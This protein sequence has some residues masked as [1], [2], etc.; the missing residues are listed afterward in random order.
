M[1]PGQPQSVGAL[2]EQ[3]DAKVII[4]IINLINSN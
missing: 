1:V 3:L 2:A 4:F